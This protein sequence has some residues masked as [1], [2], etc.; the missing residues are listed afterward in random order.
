MRA[1]MQTLTFLGFAQRVLEEAGKPLSSDDI[2][3]VGKEKGYTSLLHSGGKTPWA[4][5]GAQLY[6][7]VRD[8]KDSPFVK[9]GSRPSLFFLKHLLK[10]NEQEYLNKLEVAQQPAAKKPVFLEKELHPF[11]AQFAYFFLKAHTKTI[12]HSK[13][14][15]REYGEWVHPDMVGCYFPLEDWKP[16]VIEFSSALGNM[17]VKLFSFE[18]KRE[19]NFGNLRESFFQTVSNSSWAHEGF[20]VAADIS[21]NEEFQ[22]ELR[23][24]SIS[25]GIGVIR[26][27]LSDPNSSETIFPPRTKEY[28]DWDTINKLTMNPDFRDFLKRVKTDISSK[29]I[30]R[31][32]YDKV[33]E[34]DDLQKLIK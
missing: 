29:E 26:L 31:E 1:G 19:L 34:A 15:K 6:V 22:S 32:K 13:S 17:A 33:L 25:F 14:D 10:G 24:L 9:L 4:T 18:L 16:E 20:L 7:S 12:Q 21:T 8:K 11:L 5:L 30:R 28:L 23:R 27:N 3:Q 2:W